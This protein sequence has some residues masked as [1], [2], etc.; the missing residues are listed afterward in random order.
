MYFI[1]YLISFILSIFILL[2]FFRDMSALW[3][4]YHLIK[5]TRVCPNCGFRNNNS[6]NRCTRCHVSNIHDPVTDPQAY[7]MRTT[8]SEEYQNHKKKK[9]KET[10]LYFNPQR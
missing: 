10:P 3:K 4:Y 5:N 7:K 1:I 2:W 8:N 6:M 9:E